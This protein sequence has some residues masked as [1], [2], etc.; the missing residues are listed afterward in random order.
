MTLLVLYYFGMLLESAVIL[1]VELSVVGVGALV[2]WLIVFSY[3]TWFK[4]IC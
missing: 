2:I 4:Y 3:D 1:L